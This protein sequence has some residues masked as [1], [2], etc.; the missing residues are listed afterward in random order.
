MSQISYVLHVD[1]ISP[2]Q[3]GLDGGTLV[4]ITGAG[5]STDE[6]HDNLIAFG[7]SPCDVVMATSTEIVCRAGS[8][9][10]VHEVTNNGEDPGG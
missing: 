9:G 5:F 1:S 4:T 10:T 7:E 6:P 2:Q 8:S 3:G